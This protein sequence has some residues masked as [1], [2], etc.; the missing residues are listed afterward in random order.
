MWNLEI[1][2]EATL[3]GIKVL[4]LKLKDNSFKLRVLNGDK[5]ITYLRIS[6]KD[7]NNYFN[8]DESIYSRG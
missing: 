7:Y 3:F 5:Y 8:K 2:Q 6:E 4:I 1:A